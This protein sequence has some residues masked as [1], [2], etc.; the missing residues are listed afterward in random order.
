MRAGGNVTL[1]NNITSTGGDITLAGINFIN[2]AGASALTASGRWLVYANTHTGNTFG[3]LDSANQA[4]WNTAYPTAVSQTGN[5]YV[6]ANNPGTLTVTSTNQTKTYGQDGAL[7]VANAYNVTGTFIN[8][9]TFG[10]VFTQ[11][12]AANTVTGTA[13]STGSTVTANVGSYAIDMTPITANNGYTLTKSNLGNLTVN[14]ANITVSS[15]DVVKTYDATTSAAGA[16]NITSGTLFNGNILTGGTFAFTNAN[17]GVGNKTVTVSGV[18]VNDGNAGGNY[19]VTLANN[20]TSTINK[21]NASVTANSS[22]VTYNGLTQ[23][24][25]GF[26]ATGLVGGETTAVLTGVSTSGGS[27]QNAGSYSHTASGTDGNYNLAFTNGALTINK[28]N[29]SVTANSNNVTYNG[30]TQSVTGFTAT[31]LVN[32]ETT[33]VLTGVSTSGGSGQNVGSYSHLASGTDSNYNLAFING[34]L[35]I[36]PANLTVTAN[37]Q[38]KT[39]GNTFIFAGTEFT[40]SGLQNGETIGSVSLASPGAVNTANVNFYPILASLAMGGTFDANNYNISY[41]GGNF[42]VDQAIINL[43]GTRSYNATTAFNA[44]DFGVINGVLGQTLNLTGAGSVASK[45]VGTQTVAIGSLGLTNGT[46]SASNYTLTGGAY[47]GTINQANLALNAFSNTKV[48]DGTTNLNPFGP[49][50]PVGT[51]GLFSPDTVTATQSFASKNVLGTNGSTLNVDAGYTVNDGNGGNNYNVTTNSATGTI[52]PLG[53]AGTITANNKVY[54][55]T[56]T[57][58]IATRSLTG[59]IAGDTV[60]YAGGTATFADKNVSTGKTVTAIG[61]GLTGADAGNYTVNTTATST[62]DIS[63]S[64]ISAVT[65]ITANNKTYDATTTASLNTSGAAFTGIFG[66]DVLNV[67][68]ATGAFVDANAG[69][70]K[71]V[72]I[73]GISLG[74]ADAGNYNLVSSTAS[75]TADINKAA[76]KVTAN[77]ATKTQGSVNPPFSSSFVG[78]V[79]GETSTVLTGVLGHNTLAVTSSPAGSYSITPFGLSAANYDITFVDGVL[80]VVQP[81]NFAALG[82]GFSPA[83]TRP[84]QAT[85]TCGGGAAN[86]NAMISGLEA[87]GADDV[88]Y[89]QLAS[90]PLI[91]GV[92]ANALVSPA[93]LKL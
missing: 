78:F 58:T 38:T 15:S 29:A 16:A 49:I 65:G 91:G 61:L 28:A 89:K 12:T 79:G 69:L 44:G 11:D 56:N 42:R 19:N 30:L 53:I 39:Y 83:L 73:S 32:S 37:N 88:E 76:L 27:G 81:A 5:R 72:N 47:T 33:A 92:V 87:F 31:G 2:N 66:G 8:A 82:I 52:T 55:A 7:T 54:D 9:A 23:S 41:S 22:N 90:Q 35:S 10:N 60:T 40:A 4:V 59:V 1:A 62:A 93:C 14:K 86:D 34:A 50:G 85:Q 43:N 17:A 74:G 25:T 80:S 75:A 71:T 36:N 84:Q 24:V 70:I 77:N 67:S 68:T 26:T 51:A 6:F 3:A 20:T 45:N 18:T 63:K 21:A 57:A 64:N 46:G 13:T 48:Y